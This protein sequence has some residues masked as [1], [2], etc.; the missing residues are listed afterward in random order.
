MFEFISAGLAVTTAVAGTFAYLYRKGRTDGID[1]ACE[2]RIKEKIQE[3]SDL[4]DQKSRANDDIHDILFKN[5][6]KMDGKIDT[7]I[8]STEVIKE[9]VTKQL[10]K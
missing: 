9:L 4:L 5:M 2:N 3:V 6:N 10:T 8:G 1:Q 7:L